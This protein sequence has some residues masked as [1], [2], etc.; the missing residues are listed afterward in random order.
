MTTER[1]MFER[2]FQRPSNYFKLSA[3]T[4]WEIDK[5]LGIL[6]WAGEGLTEE[7]M[8]RFRNHY[9]SSKEYS[10]WAICVCSV[11]LIITLIVAIIIG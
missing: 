8:E 9:E 6:D 7:D 1:E 3:E 5:N 10:Y 4:Q 11:L 2:S